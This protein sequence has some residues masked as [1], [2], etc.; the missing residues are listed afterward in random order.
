MLLASSEI[1]RVSWE[2][3]E[4]YVNVTRDS[5]KNRPEYDPSQPLP[6]SDDVARAMEARQHHRT[7]VGSAIRGRTPK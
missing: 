7:S 3:H 1:E 5:I 6:A 4:V 2:D